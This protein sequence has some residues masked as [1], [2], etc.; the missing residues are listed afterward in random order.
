MLFAAFSSAKAGYWLTKQYAAGIT[1][2]KIS[3]TDC[4]LEVPAQRLFHRNVSL[5]CYLQP[6]RGTLLRYFHI[7]HNPS[8]MTILLILFVT[9][10]AGSYLQNVQLR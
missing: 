9:L 7:P 2:P 10:L 8:P 4:Q 5:L 6:C 3:S 1:V